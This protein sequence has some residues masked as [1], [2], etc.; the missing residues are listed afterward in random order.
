MNKKFL[1]GISAAL[2]VGV[3]AV[4]WAQNIVNYR[5]Q[6]GART[7]IG[8]SLDVVS[9]GDLDIESGAAFKIAGSDLAAELAILD[10]V[11]A[12]T[13][14]LNN[15]TNFEQTLSSSTTVLTVTDGV[16]DFDVASHDTSNGLKLGGTLVTST[17]A[18]LNAL[19]GITST[20]AKLN[21]V[22]VTTLGTVEASLAVT[23]DASLDVT[24]LRNLTMT[25]DL[26]ISDPTNGGD[27]GARNTLTANFNI[28]VAAFGTM[29]NGST[30]TI[31]LFD[32]TPA[33]ECVEVG[34][35]T[36]A[37][38][39]A[40]YRVGTNSLKVTLEATPAADEG[41]DCTISADDFGSN[42][43]IGFWFRTDTA[44]TA[45]GDLF[46]ELDDDGGTDVEF[47]FPTV[48]TINQWTWI[49]L[50]ISTCATCDI[51][52]GVKILVDATGATTLAGANFWLDFMYKWDADDE[53]ALGVDIVQDGV[54]GVITVVDAAG[55]NNTTTARVENT[56]FFINYQVGNDAWVTLTDLST[57]TGFGLFATQ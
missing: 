27:A 55:T 56:D 48:A 10:G 43:S 24:A 38:D 33:G 34:G 18:E 39:A 50:D 45:S 17:A 8:G 23:A 11:T 36:A 15:T 7:V 26:T 9:G 25:G 30:E 54:L 29:T 13:A 12:S 6:G 4:A 49:E 21:Y 46:L 16:I 44:L 53:E 41:V 42:E 51:V 14:D 28:G 3:A 32:D 22:D 52:N 57:F 5:E 47:D 2:V 40:V 37:N 31:A 35:Q 20:V 19:D 1:I